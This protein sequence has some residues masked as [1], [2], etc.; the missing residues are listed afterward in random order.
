MQLAFLQICDTSA[1][2]KPVYSRA[3][4]CVHLPDGKS[5][6]QKVIVESR[7]ATLAHRRYHN[8]GW[9]HTILL[10]K[11]Y[12]QHTMRVVADQIGQQPMLTGCCSSA[13]H[14]VCLWSHCIQPAVQDVTS[15]YIGAYTLANKTSSKVKIK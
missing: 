4:Q 1:L 13:M 7:H 11:Y 5:T 10:H 3:Q 15:T 14:Y 9:F 12:R 8:S 2:F 6:A